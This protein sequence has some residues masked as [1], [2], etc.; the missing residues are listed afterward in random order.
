MARSYFNL[1]GR[2][3]Q[4]MDAVHQLGEASVADVLNRLPDPPS[5]STVR[6]MLRLLEK[7]GLLKHRRD[8]LRY[9]Y[10]STES[11]ERTRRS[12]L[13]HL[14]TTFFGGSASDAVAAVLDESADKMS[15]EDLDRLAKLIDD[16][17][18]AGR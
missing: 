3:R 10:R 16:A 17:R 14:L 13:Q 12:A 5:Y 9:V 8:G 7:K 6:T 4:I 2:E 15:D 18:R 1:G 11:P